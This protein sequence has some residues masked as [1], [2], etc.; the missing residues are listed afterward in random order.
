MFSISTFNNHNAL[1]NRQQEHR[2]AA[3][4]T[5]T[6][7]GQPPMIHADAGQKYGTSFTS[8]SPARSDLMMIALSWQTLFV[9]KIRRLKVVISSRIGNTF[10]DR[11]QCDVRHPSRVFNDITPPST[12]EIYELIRSM[13]AKSS[14]AD[15]TSTSV[16]KTWSGCVRP[17][18]SET[19]DV[20]FQRRQIS[21]GIQASRC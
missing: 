1:S 17:I 13:P 9:E 8:S 18:D 4:S 2:H 21:R 19:R 7:Y 12:V 16:I 6:A 10:A 11:P 5:A 14:P 3:T 20:I 15:I